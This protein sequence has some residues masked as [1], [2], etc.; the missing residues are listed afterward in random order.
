MCHRSLEKSK[1]SVGLYFEG[2]SFTTLVFSV[3]VGLKDS[4]RIGVTT[5]IRQKFDRLKSNMRQ[6]VVGKYL[7]VHKR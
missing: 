6:E 2:F 5:A 3:S 4:H 1:L 7:G